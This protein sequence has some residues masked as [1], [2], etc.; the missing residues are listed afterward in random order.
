LTAGGAAAFGTEAFSTVEAER[1]VDVDVAD[2]AKAY[3]AMQAASSAVAADHVDTSDGVIELDFSSTDD[4]AGEGVNDEALTKFDN[5]FKIQNQGSQS[6]NVYVTDQ[7]DWIRFRSDGSSIEGPSNAVELSP[8]EEIIVSLTIDTTGGQSDYSAGTATIFGDGN[9]PSGSGPVAEFNRIVTGTSGDSGPNKYETI[10]GAID[11]ASKNDNI[12]IE[13]GTYGEALSIKSGTHPDGLTL[14]AKSGTPTIDPNDNSKQVINVAGVKDITIDGIEVTQSGSVGSDNK[15]ADE[16]FGIRV[17]PN[18]GRSPDRVSI[19]NTTVKDIA[20]GARATG[21][22]LNSTVGSPIGES[23]SGQSTVS[24]PEIVNCKIKNIRATV[25]AVNNGGGEPQTGTDPWSSSDFNESKAKGIAING[26]VND[27]RVIDTDILDIGLDGTDP[28]TDKTGGI[29]IT[30]VIPDD[31][32]TRK[33]PTDFEIRRVQFGDGS[34]GSLKGQYGQPSIFIGE[35]PDL[36]NNH[37]VASNNFYHPVDNFSLGNQKL[38][39]EQ[40]WWDGG[41]P[42]PAKEP[43]DDDKDGGVLINRRMGTDKYSLTDS[44]SSKAPNAGS[45]L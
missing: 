37:V 40:N 12:G 25:S 33:G 18:S 28:A 27:A 14:Q 15:G 41:S 9:D 32:D 17:E 8:G 11:A 31:T 45:T 34:T 13:S 10:Q 2:D 6:A 24:K 3:L 42:Q 39:L 16:Q 4:T 36:G 23:A 38:T 22:S 29:R 20:E 7:A 44:R 1:T 30:E 21:I 19:R 5:L 26:D 35:I 43:S